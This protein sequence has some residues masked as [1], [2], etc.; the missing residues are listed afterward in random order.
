M[1]P[2]NLFHSRNFTGANLLTLF[3]YAALSGALFFFPLNLIQV[4]GYSATAA[5]AAFLPFI[6]IMFLLSRWS[7]GLVK[8]YGAKKPLIAGPIVAALGYVLFIQ[9]GVEA[10]Y[11]KTFFPA[12][13]VLGLGMAISVAPLTTTVMNAVPE[14]LAGAASGVNN[15][16]SRTAGLLGI[17]IFGVVILPVF[18]AKLDRRLT[19]LSVSPATRSFIVEQRVRL[20]G[21]ELPESIDEQSKVTLRGAINEAFVSGF[22]VVMSSA[23]ALAL[24]SALSAFIMIEGKLRSS[25]ANEPA[26]A[27]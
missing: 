24:A 2:L 12:I 16:V 15:A 21:I 22:R 26:S 6:F 23:A 11:W 17:A 19:E 13:V 8:S 9:P 5:G 3:L 7:G 1:L 25:T 14:R 18:A 27:T 10:D 4:Q 20:A